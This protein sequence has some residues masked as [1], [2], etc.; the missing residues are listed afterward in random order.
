MHASIRVA[1]PGSLVAAAVLTFGTTTAYAAPAA[2]CGQPAVDAVYQTIQVPA[3]TQ[4]VPAVTHLAWRWTRQMPTFDAEY[5]RTVAEGYDIV[6]WSRTTDVL[7][8]EY[9]RTVIDQAAVPAVPGTPE[10]GHFVT[11]TV[12]TETVLE[13]E[14]IHQQSGRTRW[15]APGWNAGQGG[16]GWSPTGNVHYVTETV[17]TWVVDQ[18][19]VPEIPAI[20]EVSHVEYVWGAVGATPPGY[21]A[22]GGTRVADTTVEN[23]NLPEG[24]SPAGA[25][26]VMGAVVDVVAPVIEL[27]W[28]PE[29]DG[30]PAGYAPTG[31][32][33]E[34]GSVTEE[35]TEPSAVAPA[36]DGWA[37][38]DGSEVTVVD[39][40]EHVVVITPATT[41]EVLVTPAVPATA[42]CVD[43]P[44]TGN[45][46]TDDPET[47]DPD[48]D[49]DS[50]AGTDVDG[51]TD[52]APNGGQSVDE[53]E[54]VLPATGSEASPWLLGAGAGSL[55]AGLVLVGRNR[56]VRVTG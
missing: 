54:A 49:I 9:S 2:D 31:N 3:V 26:W 21:A 18:P 38:V 8:A 11:E 22:T 23:V 51:P 30:T 52:Q 35:T 47:D 34:S 45:P 7:E 33:V 10:V 14:F 40:P 1:V 29:A 53:D 13:V 36:G 5:S 41:Q 56:R 17:Q 37:Q 55:L 20:P 32:R 12:E 24:E 39:S 4:T 25:G 48:T 42:P 6:A 16:L 43:D 46:V 19:A 50:G 15:E 44:N 28:A 27:L